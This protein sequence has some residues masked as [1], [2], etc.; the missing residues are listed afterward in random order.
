MDKHKVPQGYSHP[1]RATAAR[2]GGSVR[3]LGMDVL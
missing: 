1:K 2:F 3:P